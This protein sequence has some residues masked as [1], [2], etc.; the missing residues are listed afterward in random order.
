MRPTLAEQATTPAARLLAWY[1]ARARALPWRLAPGSGEPADPYRVWLSEIMLQQTTV[2][3]AAP[4]FAAFVERWPTVEALAAAED[5][6]L[7]QA[8]A[9]LGYYARARNLLA[10]ARVVAAQGG[11]PRTAAGL[12]ALPGVGPYTAAA[13]A[14]IA[15]GEPAVAIDAN[16]ERVGSRLFALEEPLPAGRARLEA[17]LSTLLPHDR[18]GDFTQALMDLGATVC[19]VRAPRCLLC[20]LAEGCR[21]RALGDPQAYPRKAARKARPLRRG[22]VWWVEHRGEV[23]LVRRPPRGLLGGMLALPGSD[24]KE[25]DAEWQAP[26]L[27]FAANWRVLPTPVRHGFTHFE[28]ELAVAQAEAPVRFETLS[29]LAVHWTPRA[30]VADAGLPTLFAKAATAALQSLLPEAA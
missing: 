9:G 11:F 13:I 28:L 22:T 18:P 10:A 5:G 21:A 3:A 16:I 23:A 4:R 2:A 27:P 20:P 30:A 19:T 29:E 26:A 24:W 12:R 15:F 1:E 25:G 6:A 17:A 14:A 8:W 7:M